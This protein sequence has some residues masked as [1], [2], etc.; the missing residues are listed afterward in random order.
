MTPQPPL[1]KILKQSVETTRDAFILAGACMVCACPFYYYQT[2][3]LAPAI[4]PNLADERLARISL[5]FHMLMTFG[6]ALISSMVGLYY[7]N[8]LGLKG[9]DNLKEF[10]RKIL[11]FLALGILLIPLSYVS[12]DRA[13]MTRIP[14]YY[15]GNIKLAM[16]MPLIVLS[17]EVIMRFGFITIFVYLLRW[18]KFHRHPWPAS[19][20]VAAFVAGQAYMSL[21]SL[22]IIQ[23]FDL[24]ALRL[25]GTAFILNL[26]LGEIY[27]RKGIMPAIFTHLGL[28]AKYLLYSALY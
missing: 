26:L 3:Y 5:L 24:F 17:I 6:A 27:I 13:I 14:E 12:S 2:K 9:F 8:R 21:Q 1:V 18:L 20:M 4:Q 28:E 10:H 22:D 25:V 15:P 7:A 23:G 11:P 16:G 19:L